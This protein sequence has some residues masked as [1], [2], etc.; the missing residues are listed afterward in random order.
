MD[1]FEKCIVVAMI[2]LVLMLVVA[3]EINH[4]RQHDTLFQLRLLGK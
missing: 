2:A 3:L 1:Q 4:S